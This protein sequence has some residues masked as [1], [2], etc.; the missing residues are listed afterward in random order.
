[1]QSL[2]KMSERVHSC[3]V[4]RNSTF[5]NCNGTVRTYSGIIARARGLST[6]VRL[7][8]KHSIEYARKEACCFPFRK[9]V[10]ALRP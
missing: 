8:K 10:R 9:A 1:V 6:E 5:V 2:Y 4:L 3:I 7:C